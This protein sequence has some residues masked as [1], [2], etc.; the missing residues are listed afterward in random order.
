MTLFVFLGPSLPLPRARE[1]TDA[2]YLPPVAMGH[3]YTLVASRARPG[4]HVAIIDGLF[5]QVPAVWH[6]EVLYALSR[7]VNVHGAA[8]MGALRA[9]ELHPFGMR[10]VGRIFEAFAS[11]ALTNDDE[12]VVAH[13]QADGGFRSLSTALV[14]IRFGLADLAAEGRVPPE[15]ADA[16]VEAAARLPYPQRSWAAVLEEAAARGAPDAA[17]TA[18]RSEAARPDAKARDASALLKL[19]SRAE[20]E[21]FRPGFAFQNTSFWT[22]MT[23]SMAARVDAARLGAAGDSEQAAVAAF[24]RA[25]GPDRD[26]MLD[27]ALLD[28]LVLDYDRGAPLEP[29]ELREAA[30]RI[31]RRHQLANGEALMRWRERHR[32]IGADWRHAVEAEARRHRVRGALAG[33]LDVL[34]L[35]RLKAEGAF[36][37]VREARGRAR[38]AID[39]AAIAKP[40][41]ADFG[42]DADQLERWYGTRFGPMSPDPD[43]HA[44]A[45]GF[46][47]LR[48]FVNALLEC[49]LAEE[50]SPAPRER[51]AAGGRR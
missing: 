50:G 23:R 35:A 4:D 25:A 36:E 13:A 17:V 11:G 51:Q 48:D 16:L 47:S 19:L 12:V 10:G 32:L 20:A 41:L 9:S 34:L 18:I 30:L 2:V 15:L 40:S 43:R 27:G 24:V 28:R 42:L 21:P 6:K 37:A 5:E 38:E 7:G 22:A 31:A 33:Q 26:R 45:L 14:S 39:A 8:S 49:Y 46:E 3:L 44:R 1:I 29:G